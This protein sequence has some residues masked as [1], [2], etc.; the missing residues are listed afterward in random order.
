MPDAA[1]VFAE[2][3]LGTGEGSV[4]P[5]DSCGMTLGALQELL[6]RVERQRRAIHRLSARV[7]RLRAAE[8]R[9][10]PSATARGRGAARR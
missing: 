2:L 3:G 7:D 4:H 6:V 8:S 10:V 5:A 9:P 1:K